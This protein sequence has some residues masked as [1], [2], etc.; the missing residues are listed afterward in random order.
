MLPLELLG[1]FMTA[2][3]ITIVTGTSSSMRV[4][5]ILFFSELTLGHAEV[6]SAPSGILM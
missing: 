2:T 5:E 4:R 1:G 6:E 3:G